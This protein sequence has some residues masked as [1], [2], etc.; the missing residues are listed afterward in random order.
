MKSNISLV[1]ALLSATAVLHGAE[2]L[3]GA[4]AMAAALSPSKPALEQAAGTS[5]QIMSK[6][7][8]KGLQDLCAGTCNVA[9]VTGSL[10]SAAAGANQERAGSVSLQGL[11]AVEVG[12]DPILFVVHPSNAVDSLTLQQIKGILSGTVRNWKEVGGSDMPI[13]VFSLGA[14]NGPRIAVNEQLL[15]GAPVVTSA[16]TRE[17][18]KDICPIV[19]QKP[20]GFGFVGRS[21]FGAG[22]K[23]LR[24]DGAIAMP[25]L[26]VTRGKP[27]DTQAKIIEASRQALSR[28]G[29]P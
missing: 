4:A 8:G 25:M 7:A 2:T 23:V 15:G 10:E 21:N 12:S 22:V 5:I 9:M 28:L 26:L 20:N 1:I 16:I 14:R 13:T 24:T 3:S 27:T 11:E 17:T 6:N 29:Q 18:P 19:A